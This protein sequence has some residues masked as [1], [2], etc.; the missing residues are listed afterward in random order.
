MI[1]ELQIG[2]ET[3][4]TRRANS[5][6]AQLRGL[7]FTR[8]PPEHALLLTYPTLKTRS[9]HMLFVPYNITAVFIKYHTVHAVTRLAAWTGIARGECTAILEVPAGEYEINE[10]DEVTY[11]TREW[12]PGQAREVNA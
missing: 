7:T 4:P 9:I 12:A 11:P 3:I 1:R 2:N 8:T 5:R 6:L 10:L